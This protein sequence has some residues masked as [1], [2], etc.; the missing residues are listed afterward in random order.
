[1]FN[2]GSLSF[3][4]DFV[5]NNIVNVIYR[6]ND[7]L[8]IMVDF[9]INL[10]DK[11]GLSGVSLASNFLYAFWAFVLLYLVIY[12][13]VSPKKF[14]EK[15]LQV[16]SEQHT[17]KSIFQIEIIKVFIITFIVSLLL[18]PAKFQYVVMDPYSPNE[19]NIP[20]YSDLK[21][22]PKS[23]TIDTIGIVAF[24]LWLQSRFVY[25]VQTSSG[26]VDDNTPINGFSLNAVNPD[27]F[28]QYFAEINKNIDGHVFVYNY[29]SALEE[30]DDVQKIEKGKYFNILD[31][32]LSVNLG[33]R[34]LFLSTNKTDTKKTKQFNTEWNLIFASS[35]SGPTSDFNKLYRLLTNVD[36]SH[37]V[38]N[39]FKAS[40]S[41]KWDLF[42]D[43]LGEALIEFAT[44]PLTVINNAGMVV[45]GK[46][47]GEEKLNMA[48]DQFNSEDKSG[49]DVFLMHVNF[50]KNSHKNNTE[51][52]SLVDSYIQ[53]TITGQNPLD[54]SDSCDLTQECLYLNKLD[55]ANKWFL[56]DTFER[57]I[58]LNVNSNTSSSLIGN[59]YIA[60]NSSPTGDQISLEDYS[61]LYFSKFL[62]NNILRLNDKIESLPQNEYMFKNGIQLFFGLSFL[63]PE[64][65]NDSSL[66]EPQK[67]QLLSDILS[68]VDLTGRPTQLFDNFEEFS[69]S[70][71]NSGILNAS[72][73]YSL[74]HSYPEQI[75]K[76][77]TYVTSNNL[78]TL[79]NNKDYVLDSNDVIYGSSSVPITVDFSNIVNANQIQSADYSVKDKRVE[80]RIGESL[81]Y[82]TDRYNDVSLFKKLLQPLTEEL[83]FEYMFVSDNKYFTLE[84]LTPDKMNKL[85]LT[86]S[87]TTSNFDGS[88]PITNEQKNEH[89]KNLYL[90]DDKLTD[91]KDNLAGGAIDF[92]NFEYSTGLNYEI[93]KVNLILNLISRIPLQSI[94]IKDKIKTKADKFILKK[95]LNFLNHFKKLGDTDVIHIRNND[96]LF[97]V[98]NLLN[99]TSAY[100]LQ[101]DK[102]FSKSSVST[103]PFLL[104]SLFNLY[105]FPHAMLYFEN[106][107]RSTKEVD[108][109][110]LSKT[111]DGLYDFISPSTKEEFTKVFGFWEYSNKEISLKDSSQSF[112]A[113]GT[114]S[115]DTENKATAINNLYSNIE[116][117]TNLQNSNFEVLPNIEDINKGSSLT[118]QQ[119]TSLSESLLS[120]KP[121]AESEDNVDPTVIGPAIATVSEEFRDMMIWATNN[122]GEFF[123]YKLLSIITEPYHIIFGKSDT[124]LASDNS[125][126]ITKGIFE[127]SANFHMD[128]ISLTYG[129]QLE[130]I[131]KL[132][133]KLLSYKTEIGNAVVFLASL[134]LPVPGAGIAGGLVIRAVATVASKGKAIANAVKEA[135]ALNIV[136]K[137]GSKVSGVATGAVERFAARSLYGKIYG[138]LSFL[139][140][141]GSGAYALISAIISTFSKSLA[142]LGVVVVAIVSIFNFLFQ[143]IV[144]IAMPLGF[145]IVYLI[146]QSILYPF[147]YMA[148]D[149]ANEFEGSFNTL[150]ENYINIIKSI[151]KNLFKLYVLYIVFIILFSA[152][153][154][155]VMTITT[156]IGLSLMFEYQKFD[157]PIASLVLFGFWFSTYFLAKVIIFVIP[158]NH[159]SKFNFFKEK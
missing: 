152:V 128:N 37:P 113:S 133:S 2:T 54:P 112:D 151:L 126:S 19:G 1:M 53:T 85:G 97:E 73:A 71:Y 52:N 136:S 50:L 29:L 96:E 68:K 62:A 142:L 81:N 78:T 7:I 40:W 11:F 134:A 35:N 14:N 26:P 34:N 8:N 102:L 87:C 122:F 116:L 58:N 16:F 83:L 23:E 41:G 46:K 10:G 93:E 157:I 90:Y 129:V 61:S 67:K 153:Y 145:G 159:I 33:L 137:V 9:F 109:I 48:L 100:I 49:F 84:D 92:Y 51:Y 79:S 138:I 47:M 106:N 150:L 95:Y 156:N 70:I 60:V 4:Q 149:I 143:F 135:K 80:K 131:N 111:I 44:T 43:G 148:K 12:V 24:S 144:R 104:Q 86:L 18:M 118:K 65:L 110:N 66:G 125:A 63:S 120:A 115:A 36:G 75:K 45:S 38:E 89:C 76:Y 15:F 123:A 105:F 32:Q 130:P 140:N 55:L 56:K 25:G 94:N 74:L 82:I 22:H 155:T 158:E 6:N 28:H 72:I 147:V 69:A 91:L 39:F 127:S 119:I 42:V 27:L 20:T 107:M 141:L 59:K 154:K 114:L 98:F 77:K 17:F 117:M 101:I 121:E 3:I 30:V 124:A 146:L 31:S 21:N 99:V 5:N 108:S 88:A 132:K 103:N 13:F 139:S 64:V 57:M